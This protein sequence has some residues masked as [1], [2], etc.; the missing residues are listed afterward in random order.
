MSEKILKALMQLFAIL[1][2]AETSESENGTEVVR[3]FL[4]ELLSVELVEQYLD[5][6]RTYLEELHKS[7]KKK[8]GRVTHS[9]MNKYNSFSRSKTAWRR[10]TLA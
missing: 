5:V 6:Y 9:S 10:M 8:E 4:N 7:S 2:G 1:A 3:A